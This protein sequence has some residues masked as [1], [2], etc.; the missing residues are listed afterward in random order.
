MARGTRLC[1]TH[2]TIVTY[3]RFA[4]THAHTRACAL[5][6]ETKTTYK[7]THT[8]ACACMGAHTRTNMHAHRGQ[9][10]VRFDT[11][12]HTQSCIHKQDERQCDLTRKKP[13]AMNGEC[14]VSPLSDYCNTLQHTATHH[15]W[16]MMGLLSSSLFLLCFFA[17]SMAN[18]GSLLFLKTASNCNMLQHAATLCN[19]LQHTATHCNTLQHTATHCNTLQHIVNGE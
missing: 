8:C 17:L 2:R 12:M 6:Q 13:P 5:I 11:K 1:N 4:S 3:A 16:Q 14:W 19:T 10:R 7:Y 15:E 9:A 18:G